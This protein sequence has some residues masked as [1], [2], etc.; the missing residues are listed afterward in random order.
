MPEWLQWVVALGGGTTIG[1]F[2]K[3]F[4][5]N[6]TNANAHSIALLKTYQ[7]DRKADREVQEKLHAKVDEV[8]ALYADER[9]Y[10]TILLAWGLAGAPPP[11]PARRVHAPSE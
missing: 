11:P 2:L 8:L 7:E 3:M 9:D 1:A 6:K 10:S 5:D 4:M